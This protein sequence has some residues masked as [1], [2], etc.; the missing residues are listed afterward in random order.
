LFL[1]GFLLGDEGGASPMSDPR[2][3]RMRASFPESA[4]VKRDTVEV[5]RA[6]IA[7]ILVFFELV[8]AELSS[9]IAVA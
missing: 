4:R 1:L 5:S 9:E 6:R 8:D 2:L 7:V 3:A